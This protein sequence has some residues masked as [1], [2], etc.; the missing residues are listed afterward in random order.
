MK[1]DIEGAEACALTAVPALWLTGDGPLWIVEINPGALA[2]FGA[3]PSEV[4][5]NFS[6]KAF[7]LQ[8]LPKH[9]LSEV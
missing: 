4:V 2:R 5:R 3:S 9:P 1:I 7:D 6:A 8:L